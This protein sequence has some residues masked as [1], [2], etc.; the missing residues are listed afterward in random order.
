MQH[1][2]NLLSSFYVLSIWIILFDI[3]MDVHCVPWWIR[4]N[5][6]STNTTT[7]ITNTSIN[8]STVVNSTVNNTQMLLVPVVVTN[9]TVYKLPPCA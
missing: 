6:N 5:S 3:V 1:K 8:S 4:E 2:I 7:T 9:P